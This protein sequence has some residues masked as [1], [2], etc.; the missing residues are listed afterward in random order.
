MDR[1]SAVWEELDE[2]GVEADAVG[3]PEPDV[4]VGEAEAGRG[5]RVG[6]GQTR[7]DRYVDQLFLKGHQQC[8]PGH[9]YASHSVKQSVHV[10]HHF[11][12]FS[13]TQAPFL[14]LSL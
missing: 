10:R 13:S 6:L 2:P 12:A 5:D 11:P 9:R 7:E 14:S 8:H 1:T 3:G 4:L